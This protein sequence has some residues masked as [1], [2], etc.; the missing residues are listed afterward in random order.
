MK[1]DYLVNIFKER[2]HYTPRQKHF[3]HLV[4]QSPW[5]LL[6]GI[7]AFTLT[8]G[9]AMYFH[10]Y[11]WG[12]FIM[13]LG[14][15]NVIL[16]MLLWWRDVLREATFQGHHTLR[17]QWGLKMGFILF[18]V[19]EIMFF[20]AW[21]WAFFHS[22]LAPAVQIGS[23]WPPLG[24]ECLNPFHVPLL[25]TIVL[26]SSG[27]TVTW[28]H[29]A[30]SENK[31]NE[32]VFSLIL[33]ILLGL[34]FTFLQALEYLTASFFISD[35]IYG[36]I[37]YM[38]TGFH[39]FHVICGTI[40]LIVCLF[41]ILNN[42]VTSTRHIGYEFAIWYWHFV[43]IVWLFVFSLIYCWGSNVSQFL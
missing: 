12:F 43:D 18:V 31:Y 13:I 2:S 22:S 37:F 9:S 25:N 40:F 41:R 26:L 17:V 16:I 29:H 15:L 36:S 33:T 7:A 39:G 3:F 11:N 24:I 35:S 20:I 8:T 14:L 4:T 23:V 21:F 30:I 34:D 19:S 5:P 42:Q 38:T 6:G 28:S 10:A 27:V 1:T 32:T